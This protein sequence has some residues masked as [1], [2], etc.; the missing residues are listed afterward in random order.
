MLRVGVAVGAPDLRLIG[1]EFDPSVA[2]LSRNIGQHSLAYLRLQGRQ[3]EYQ[4][5]LG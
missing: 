4:L 2:P 5:R 1:R 3:I